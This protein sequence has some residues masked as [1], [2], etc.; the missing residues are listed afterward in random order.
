MN[1]AVKEER[2]KEESWG[3]IEKRETKGLE[4]RGRQKEVY[5]HRGSRNKMK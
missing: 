3:K 1:K 5:I 4:K 2:K